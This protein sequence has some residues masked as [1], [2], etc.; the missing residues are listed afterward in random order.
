MVKVGKVQRLQGKRLEP[1]AFGQYDLSIQDQTEGRNE[2]HPKPIG[3]IQLESKMPK[4]W[5]WYVGV[6]YGPLV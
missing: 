3:G 5:L 4:L 6:T 2:S 1:Q